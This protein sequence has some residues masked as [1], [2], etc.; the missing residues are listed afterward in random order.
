MDYQQTLKQIF[1]GSKSQRK[2]KEQLDKQ[3]K[4]LL[5]K[6]QKQE[7]KEERIQET[8][9][10]QLRYCAKIREGNK[11]SLRTM[12][13]RLFFLLFQNKDIYHK[14]QE[15]EHL[16]KRLDSW[17]SSYEQAIQ[18]KDWK[19][20]ESENK[21]LNNL[22]KEYEQKKK[23]IEAMIVKEQAVKYKSHLMLGNIMLTATI[24]LFKETKEVSFSQEIFDEKNRA[25]P[26]NPFYPL[27]FKA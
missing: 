10:G 19:T 26:L 16:M 22:M 9:D 20:E 4:A 14:L 13:I 18:K 7:N 21:S 23:E 6:K 2:R 1:D 15:V 24:L 5:E 11:N 3:K 17:L 25:N 8:I 27:K 12:N